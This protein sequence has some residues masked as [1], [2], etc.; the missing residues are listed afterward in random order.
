MPGLAKFTAELDCR[1]A[2]IGR[3]LE[4]RL[5]ERGPASVPLHF[6][7]RGIGSLSPFHRAALLL[8]RRHLR[9]IDRLTRDIFATVADIRNFT[10]AQVDPRRE[11]APLLSSAL[12]PER[13]AGVARWFTGLWLAWFIAIYVPDIPDTV[14]FIVLT[15]TLS[16]ALCV[17][18]QVPIA[19]MFLPVAFG[20]ALGGVVY[21]LVMPHLASFASLAGVIFAAVFSICYLFHRPAQAAVKTAALGLLVM[22]MGVVN[23]QDY[24][25]IYVINLAVAFLLIF[26]VLAVATHFPVSFRPEHVFLRLLGRFFRACAYLASTLRWDPASPRTTWQRL[27]RVLH[28][29]HLAKVPGQLAIWGSAL[30]VAAL[31][32]ST[33][34]QVQALVDSLQALA[35]RMQD[36]IEAR[37]TPQSH[38]LVRELLSEVRAWRAGLQDI[39]GNL[40]RHPEAADFADFGSRLDAMLERL[41]GRVKKAVADADQ[42]RISTQ[43]DENSILLLGAF[44][45]VSEELV[46]FARHSGGVDWARL[47]E[48]RF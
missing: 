15:N 47:R 40:A 35:Y 46:N 37:A 3:L 28:L 31:G 8:Y 2:E 11:A 14:A 9:E 21:I 38:V 1:F 33:T 22:V 39:F 10:R 20:I 24:T 17:T 43:E 30:P 26:A 36:L 5:P 32:Q 16:M 7:D 4:G 19:R 44:R 42:A 13:L 41:E 29:G 34:E 48:A 18:P 12:D 25:F 45:S 6:E 23:E 27:R